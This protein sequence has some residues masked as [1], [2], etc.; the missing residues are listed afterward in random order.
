MRCE[1]A[2]YPFRDKESDVAQF[3]VGQFVNENT[4]S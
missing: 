4:V 1:P 2:L 3:R